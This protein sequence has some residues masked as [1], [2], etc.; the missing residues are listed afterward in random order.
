MGERAAHVKKSIITDE[1]GRKTRKCPYSILTCQNVECPT[2]SKTPRTKMSKK[3]TKTAFMYL[4]YY[5][6]QAY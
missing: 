1:W 2:Q 3:I 5:A 6:L 4:F